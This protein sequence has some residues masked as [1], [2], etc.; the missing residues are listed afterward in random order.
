MSISKT[1]IISCAGTGSRLG[2]GHSKALLKIARKPL[3][4]H[5]LEQLD[6]FDDVRIVVGYDAR[7]VIEVVLSYRKNVTFVFNHNYL[8]TYTLSSLL[9]GAKFG[10]EYIVSLDGDLLV[11]P[12]DL[13]RFLKLDYE[14]M[15]YIEAYSDEPV[16]TELTEKRK[17]TYITGFNRKKGQYEWTGL[18]QIKRDK[19][20]NGKHVY[21]L[22]EKEL[23]FRAEHINCREI[24]TPDDYERAAVWSKKFF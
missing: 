15:G 1:I 8:T 20:Q 10:N 12:N 22:M 21:H 13:K 17:K 19:I 24:D 11:A 9:L 7:K 2:Y 23:P 18:V 16:Y 6:N 3:I 14:A 4:L 5:Q